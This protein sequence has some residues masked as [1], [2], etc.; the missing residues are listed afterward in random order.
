MQICG[1]PAEQLK[2]TVPMYPL[3]AVSVPYHVIGW[4]TPTEPGVGVRAI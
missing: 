4:P 1:A 3:K 2:V